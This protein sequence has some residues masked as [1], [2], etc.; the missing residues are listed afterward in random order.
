MKVSGTIGV[1]HTHKTM[2]VNNDVLWTNM[3]L[4]LKALEVD[5]PPVRNEASKSCVWKV[6]EHHVQNGHASNFQSQIQLR[7]MTKQCP[8][9]DHFEYVQSSR[10]LIKTCQQRALKYRHETIYS[11][12]FAGKRRLIFIA[13]TK[14]VGLHMSWQGI[15]IASFP[16]DSLEKSCIDQATPYPCW[17]MPWPGMHPKHPKKSTAW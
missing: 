12:N 14:S 6:K 9:D 1:T 17:N 2:T 3:I 13:D 4:K 5:L 15:R 10:V 16:N 7:T 8:N 11:G